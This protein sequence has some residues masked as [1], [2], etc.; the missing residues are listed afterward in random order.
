MGQTFN[1]FNVGIILPPVTEARL[2]PYLSLP[3]IYSYL[4]EKGINTYQ[5]D[6]NIELSQEIFNQK[7]FSNYI[8]KNKTKESNLHYFF[9]NG[10]AEFIKEQSNQLYVDVFQ[11]QH[12]D[13]TPDSKHSIRLVRQGLDLL[14]EDNFLTSKVYNF[15]QFDYEL[16]RNNCIEK[17][18]EICKTLF[19]IV[20]NFIVDNNINLLAISVP[21][22]SQILPTLVI[23]K[24][25]KK[26]NP[27]VKII[28]G[29]QQLM[30]HSEKISNLKSFDKYI[31]YIGTGKGED[32][33]YELINFLADSK[34]NKKLH[35]I[36]NLIFKND[37]KQIKQSKK[38]S[39]LHIRDLAIPEYDGLNLNGYLSADIQ[40]SIITCI[41]CVW[42]RC[43]F[44]SYGN[45]SYL[46]GS[47]EQLS[48]R[49]IA[50]ICEVLATKHNIYRINFIDENTNLTLVL[51][52]MKILNSRGI[53]INY[54]TR[55]RLEDK[56]VNIEFCEELKSSGCILMS[57]GYETNS[58]RLLNLLNKGVNPDNYQKII[59]NLYYVGINLRLSI[60]GGI[61]D[62]TEEEM[63]DSFH[64][65]SKNQKK[66]GIDIGQM[67]VAEVNTILTNDCGNKFPINLQRN[68]KYRG[69]EE[70]NYGMGRMG[71]TYSYV[72]EEHFDS[73]LKNFTRLL[74]GI[75][76]QNNDELPPDMRDYDMDKQKQL[77]VKKNI[78]KE[79]LLRKWVTIYKDESRTIV[80]DLLW[81]RFYLVEFDE[82][83]VEIFCRKKRILF[84]NKFNGK[85]NYFHR[86][87]NDFNKLE[88]IEN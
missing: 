39:K 36:P 1:R 8:K 11:K 70:L 79:F 41:G 60:M 24:W 52:A 78:P 5:A 43:I 82:M 4:K 53:K 58:K 88:L 57:V 73:K 48:P 61:L 59:D 54:S 80:I 14:L 2:F 17:T 26:I 67:L 38:Q 16:E 84:R 31:D 62:E 6:F 32:T 77:D 85:N 20:K 40:L 64:F 34:K 7:Q 10:L 83:N 15:D 72:D 76:P 86:L 71:Y 55:N 63:V 9:R 42:G 44:C 56:L 69:N 47:Y 50:D 33:I 28:I 81:Q 3:M 68:E 21:F 87:L 30:L 13:E 65:L 66:I 75:N 51:N 46:S 49:K 74:R 35:D 12:T 23:C 45:R 18:D 22:Y 27:N 25:V 37:Y 29:G 19:K